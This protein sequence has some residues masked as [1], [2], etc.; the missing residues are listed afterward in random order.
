MDNFDENELAALT[1]ADRTDIHA[2][3]PSPTIEKLLVLQDRDMRRALL[4]VQLKAVPSEIASVQSKI[5]E[6]RSAADTAKQDWKN[7][8]TRRKGLENEVTSEEEKIA[9]F[10]SQQLMVKK[11]EEY[12][13]LG[14][15]IEHAQEAVER[16]EEEEIGILLELDSAKERITAAEAVAKGNIAGHEARIAQ[17]KER[18]VNL[19]AELETETKRV[20]EARAEVDP[21]G[22][23]SYVRLARNV[24]LPVCVPLKEHKCGGCH[25]KVSSGV[26]S[27]TRAGSKLSHCDNCGRVLYWDIG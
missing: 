12:Q 20:E 27:E 18:E 21:D 26:E 3:M 1:A 10:R 9:R 15:E 16:L 22:Q 2:N 7:L 19:A 5:E 13:A 24:G 25:L 14:H 4:E 8:E 17:L 23:A 6:E 11:N